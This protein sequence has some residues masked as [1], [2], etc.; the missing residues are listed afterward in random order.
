MALVAALASERL[1]VEG[2]VPFGQG[3]ATMG[4]GNM[5]PDAKIV[6]TI[7]RKP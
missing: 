2:P 4:T 7:G 3:G 1:A 6:M 5:D